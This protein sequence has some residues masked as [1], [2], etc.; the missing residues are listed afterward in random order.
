MNFDEV[1]ENIKR[2]NPIEDVVKD[3]GHKFEKDAGKYRRVPHSGGLVV[4]VH[5]QNFFW[6]E[7]GWN[8]DVISLVEKEKGYE[9]RTAVDWLADRA[10]MDRPAWVKMDDKAIKAYRAKLSVFEIAQQLFVKWLWDDEEALTYLRG[11]GFDDEIIRKSGMGFSG[12]KTDAQYKEMRDQLG[13]YEIDVTSPAAVAM[14]GYKGDVTAWGQKYSIDVSGENWGQWNSISG[15]MGR[16]GIVYAHTWG[17]RVIYFSRRNLP[18][19]DT[20]TDDEG[21]EKKIKN[22]NPPEKLVGT[23]QPYFNH[24]YRADAPEVVIVEG[25]ADAET[26]G[27]WGYSAVALCGV[28]AEDEGIASLKSRLKNHK[29]KY[30]LLDD[31]ATGAKKRDRVAQ[32]ID[33]LTRMVSW[34]D[35]GVED[36]AKPESEAGEGDAVN[37]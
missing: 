3:L 8:G 6:A 4:N 31:D 27:V 11:R 21:N 35:L 14:L 22:F 17:G 37:E 18:G 19:H 2:A 23:R 36:E 29:K 24:V 32:A 33:P 25:P 10:Q 15:M 12:R 20:Y 13:M 28:H 26:F 7:K 5:K 30:L 16:P 34:A 1:I 9:F